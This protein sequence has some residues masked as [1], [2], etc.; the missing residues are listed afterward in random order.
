MSMAMFETAGPTRRLLP[1]DLPVRP[2]RR[3]RLPGSRATR[4][5]PPP[6]DPAA[7]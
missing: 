5:R 3:P 1:E 2:G 4:R 6:T 7:T